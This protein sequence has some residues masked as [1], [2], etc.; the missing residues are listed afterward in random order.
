MITSAE[1]EVGSYDFTTLDVIP[2]MLQ[3]RLINLQVLD[4]PGLVSGAASGKG[5]GKEVLAVVR[6]ADLVM[7]LVDAAK[8]IG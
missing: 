4:V 3:H 8:G 5:R 1:S 7:I 6:I 2:G